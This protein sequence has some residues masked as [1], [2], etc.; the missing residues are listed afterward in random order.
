MSSFHKIDKAHTFV[1]KNNLGQECH[2]HLF[3][4]EEMVEGQAFFPLPVTTVVTC[5]R[6]LLSS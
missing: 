3:I 4:P 2:F 6:A 5:V 1:E